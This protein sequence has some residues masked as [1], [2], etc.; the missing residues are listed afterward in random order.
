MNE[1]QSIKDTLKVI[2]K[3]LEEDQI[4]SDDE[5][6]ENILILNQ[7]VKD[8]GTIDQLN[9]NNLNKSEIIELLDKKLDEVFEKNFTKWLDKKIPLYLDKYFKD[10]KF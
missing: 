1:Q 6:K 9:E 7:L 4:D 3:A 2:R 5:I 8:D 10:K